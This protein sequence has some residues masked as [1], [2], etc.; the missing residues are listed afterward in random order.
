MLAA[1]S[2]AGRWSLARSENVAAFLMAT[3][4]VSFLYQVT[5]RYVFNASTPWAEEICVIAWIWSVLWCSALVARPEDDIRIDLITVA[6]PPLARRVIEGGCAVAV[7]VLF[8]I[9]LPGA[10][11]YIT[12]MR[13]ETTAALGW[14]FN[15]V[16]AVYMLFSL[17]VIVR[18]AIVL[19]QA[20]TGSAAQRFLEG[21][22]AAEL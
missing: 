20:V 18:Q 17:A 22:E 16:F 15:W 1:M 12:F 8:V 6:V 9:G 3:M 19:W 14:R 13:V 5:A 11:N 21:R 10:W 7:I 2:R 4:M